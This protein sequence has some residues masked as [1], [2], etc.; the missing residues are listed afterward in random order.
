[1]ITVSRENFVNMVQ[2][3]LKD[4]PQLNK[5]ID[6]EFTPSDI[7]FAIELTI[8]DYNNTPP[9]LTPVKF[10]SFPSLSVLLDGVLIF[11]LRSRL[12]WYARNRL[13]YVDGNISVDPYNKVG[14]YSALVQQ[15]VQQYVNNKLSL[16]KTQNL[17]EFYG[18]RRS[19]YFL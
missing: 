8:D 16:K 12:L 6:K 15:L 13:P 18:E 1:M 9:I 10:E 3:Y 5:L 11:L 14:E 17:E 4:H 7:Q 2:D 19:T